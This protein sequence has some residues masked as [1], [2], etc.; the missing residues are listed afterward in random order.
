[1]KTKEKEEKEEKN[2][3][4]K[5]E[6]EEKINLTKVSAGKLQVLTNF[7]L[8]K[9]NSLQK[10]LLMVLVEKLGC[11][12]EQLGFGVSII[13]KCLFSLSSTFREWCGVWDLE[14]VVGLN[15]G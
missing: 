13:W 2:E 10:L 4:E 14:W 5:E 7:I 6:L 3:E 11:F 8:T 15:V 1:M 12:C 9:H